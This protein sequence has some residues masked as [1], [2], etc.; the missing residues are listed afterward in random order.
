M[1]ESHEFV[2]DEDVAPTPYLGG[3]N[4]F[5]FNGNFANC[6]PN[7]PGKQLTHQIDSPIDELNHVENPR[8]L[9]EAQIGKHSIEPANL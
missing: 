1:D 3:E 5:N 6:N 7:F 9:P 4:Q 2:E 8:L